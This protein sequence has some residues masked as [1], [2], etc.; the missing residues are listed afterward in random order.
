MNMEKEK[1]G[2]KKRTG[3]TP[4]NKQTHAQFVWIRDVYCRIDEIK[5]RLDAIEKELAENRNINKEESEQSS[6]VDNN[7]VKE[8]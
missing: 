7:E 5:K 2:K 8:T 4:R 6:K 3:I 1:N